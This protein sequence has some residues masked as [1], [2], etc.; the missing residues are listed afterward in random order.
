MALKSGG[1]FQ[2]RWWKGGSF[3]GHP[4]TAADSVGKRGVALSWERLQMQYLPLQM[5][6]KSSYKVEAKRF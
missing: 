5:L 3:K 4:R 1:N 2:K 6:G